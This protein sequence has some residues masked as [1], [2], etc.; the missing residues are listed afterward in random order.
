MEMN[1]QVIDI[2]VGGILAIGLVL[3]FFI[4]IVQQL[5]SLGGLIIAIVFSGM[6]SPFL[7]NLLLRFDFAGPAIIHK[8]AYLFTFLILLFG[9]YFITRLVKKTVHLLHLGWIDRI[10]GCAFGIFKYTFMV[11]VALNLYLLMSKDLIPSMPQIPQ[12]AKLCE[13]VVKLA[14][15]LIDH[16]K[17]KI[18]I[19]DLSSNHEKYESVKQS[20]TV[21]I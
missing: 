8:L 18:D 15:A 10:I 19:P 4:G 1:L 7:E 20:N 12:E 17:D 21:W 14:P 2:V 11:S 6:L 13:L 5:G 16:T 3:G 9:C